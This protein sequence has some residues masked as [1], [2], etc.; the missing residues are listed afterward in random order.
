MPPGLRIPEAEEVVGQRRAIVF[1]V[2][3]DQCRAVVV[4]AWIGARRWRV[5]HPGL[6]W[7]DPAAHTV[8]VLWG[9]RQSGEQR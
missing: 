3:L 5:V 7:A 9:M 1:A 4:A 2:V 6:V 8:G